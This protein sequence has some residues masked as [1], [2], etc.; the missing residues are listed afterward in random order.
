MSVFQ[1]APSPLFQV[2]WEEKQISLSSRGLSS[3]EQKVAVT[4][5]GLEGGALASVLWKETP[6]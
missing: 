6:L 5:V 2:V 3:L 4:A 1:Y